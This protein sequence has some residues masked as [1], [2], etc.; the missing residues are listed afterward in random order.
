MLLISRSSGWP[1]K[2]KIV[3]SVLSTLPTGP[4]DNF[5]Y[6]LTDKQKQ[7]LKRTGFGITS[8]VVR[9]GIEL[10]RM[11][12]KPTEEEIDSTEQLTLNFSE[13]D[14]GSG[15]GSESEK[16]WF[17]ADTTTNLTNI[18]ASIYWTSLNGVYIV[19]GSLRIA[20][21]NA[22]GDCGNSYSYGTYQQINNPATTTLLCENPSLISEIMF[23]VETV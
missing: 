14:A 2:S 3:R 9:E 17:T 11:V 15:W 18:T 5:Y 16:I 8:Q 22:R 13:E 21:Y 10:S 4:I 19:S 6:L 23:S 7:E 1:P 20:G 12:T